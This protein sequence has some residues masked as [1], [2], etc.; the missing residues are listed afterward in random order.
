MASLI[1]RMGG[2]PTVAPSMREVPIGEN[3]AAFRFAEQLLAGRIDLVVFLTG[4]GAEALLDALNERHQAE[5][6]VASLGRAK[7]I[8][9]G[10]KPAAVLNKRGV[11]IDLKAPEP[12]TW[13]ET[14]AAVRASFDLAG[15]TVA[16]QEYGKPNEA[17]YD[18]LRALGANVVSVPVYRWALPEDTGP[19]E[20]AI[21]SAV[22]GGYDIFAFTSAQQVHNV[23]TVAERL[24]IRDAF[25]HSLR[26]GV[27]ASI[28]PTCSETLREYDLPPD[29]E[30]SP[31]KMGP[32]VRAAL[33][34]APA[35][36]SRKRAAG[37]GG[38]T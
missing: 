14:A 7:V 17:F 35:V 27:I 3:E 1:T 4:V 8:V 37:S 32:M 18:E 31:P 34:E 13:R 26:S 2:V 10:P 19:L 33:A 15:R 25:L 11:R 20:N 23:L 24:G 12:N 9:R 38:A 6:V 16:V 5:E 21:S 22:A 36:L 29:V 30:A 28:G